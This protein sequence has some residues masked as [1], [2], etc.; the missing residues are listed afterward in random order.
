M[1]WRPHGRAEVDSSRPRAW[2]TCDRCGFITNH[3]RLNV[4]RQ[5]QGTQ[6]RP[7]GFLVCRPCF[8][9]PAEFLRVFTLPPDPVPISNP[10]PENYVVNETDWRVTQD[11]SIRST[12]D[13]SLR[14]VQSS[15]TEAE[16][17]IT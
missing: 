11:G 13:G 4:E 3:H 5:W 8:D 14:V 6:L 7:T 12:Q 10:R 17:E 2:A 15:A 16:I 9:K 1:T